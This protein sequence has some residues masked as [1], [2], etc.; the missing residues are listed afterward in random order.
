MSH[1]HY[2]PI[3]LFAF[4]RPVHLVKVLA[5][6]RANREAVESDLHLFLD[7]SRNSGDES[8]VLE[9]RRLAKDIVG[10]RSVSVVERQSNFGLARNIISGVTAVLDS[11]GE[12]IVLEDDLLVSPYFL[13]YMNDGLGQYRSESRVASIH[14]YCYPTEVGL[15][16]TYFIKGADCWGW[17]TW[18]RAWSMFNPDGEQLLKD[19]EAKKLSND[20]DLNGSAGFMDM[21]KRQI[22]GLNDSWAIRWRASMFVAGM[23]TLYPG[24]SLVTN[25][26]TCDGSGT[27]FTLE[28]A[29]SVDP[30]FTEIA[31]VP[32]AVERI[33]IVESPAARRAVEAFYRK[34]GGS[35]IRRLINFAL[36]QFQQIMAR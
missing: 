18:S 1:S 35:W 33:D 21:L 8:A 30:Y 32:I 7:G 19:L 11:Y 25:I 29:G 17:G 34:L 5:S 23:Y 2:A 27:H 22:V 31:L 10:F 14:A 36:R 15:P 12:V 24:R 26:G 9:V 3:A 28:N 6:L 13:R 4:R 16:E 20:F